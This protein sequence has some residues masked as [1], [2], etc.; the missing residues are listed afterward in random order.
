[1]VFYSISATASLFAAITYGIP[2]CIADKGQG[3]HSW[4]PTDLGGLVESPDTDGHL[5]M[6]CFWLVPVGAKYP[7]PPWQVKTEVA[8]GLRWSDRV[9]YPVHVR[10]Y[11]KPAQ[12]TVEAPGQVKITVVEHGG[13]VQQNLEDY[14]RD[15]RWT[16]CCYGGNFYQ[17]GEDD[18]QWMESGAGGDIIVRV[19]VVHH[20]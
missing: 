7:V 19:D 17:Q 10:C 13:G 18:L 6:T 12:D 2:C 5:R 16:K 9:M 8:V 11:H 20:M 3:Q 14:N 1:M 15:H 4:Q